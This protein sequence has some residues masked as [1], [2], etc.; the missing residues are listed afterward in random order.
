MSVAFWST[1]LVSNKPFE[2]Q[3]P[4]GYVLNLQQ[5]ALVTEKNDVKRVFVKTLSVET[6]EEMDCCLCTLRGGSVEQ[7]SVS[8]VFGYD[9]PVTFYVTGEGKGK[10]YLSGYLQPGPELDMDDEDDEDMEGFPGEDDEDDDEEEDDEEDDEDDEA[11][12]SMEVVGKKLD[13]MKKTTKKPESS[14]ESED[15]SEPSSEASSDD[16]EDDEEDDAFVQ[17]MVQKIAKAAPDAESESESESEEEESES[18]SEEEVEPPVKVQK[19]APQGKV[20]SKHNTPAGKQQNSQK[21]NN[22]TP[23]NKPNNAKS[24]SNTPANKNNNKGGHKSNNNTPG[25]KRKF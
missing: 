19:T 8:I 23:A 22:N 10:V 7:I 15:A 11:A 2:T 14:S 9:A 1:E 24:N 20:V 18:E 4:E 12:P 21:S 16:S 3:P 6:G 17:K 25:Q 13:A 5:I